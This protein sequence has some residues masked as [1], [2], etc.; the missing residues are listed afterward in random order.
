MTQSS[1]TDVVKV[2]RPS[3]E[4]PR[5][6]VASDADLSSWEA[7]RPYLEDLRARPLPD[8]ESLLRWIR[9][10]AELG[11]AVHEEE[12]RLY[13]GM[14]CFT[15]D[16]AKQAAYLRFVETVEPAMAPVVDEL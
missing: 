5:S 15:R 13:I 8:R 9:D 14:T 3:R 16:E 11:D 7:I 1:P 2:P 4:F 6:F 12:S 10:Y